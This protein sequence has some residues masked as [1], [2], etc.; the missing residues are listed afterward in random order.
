VRHGNARRLNCT[1]VR[2]RKKISG[3]GHLSD[4]RAAPAGQTESDSDTERGDFM[5][6]NR[7]VVFQHVDEASQRCSHVIACPRTRVAA[8]VDP[9]ASLSD[10][11]QGTIEQWKLRPRWVLQTRLGDLADEGARY[12]SLLSSLGLGERALPQAAPVPTPWEDLPRIALRPPSEVPRSDVEMIEAGTLMLGLRRSMRLDQ[13][14]PRY[15]IGG[16]ALASYAGRICGSARLAFG[17]IHIRILTSASQPGVLSYLAEDR[18]FTGRPLFAPG[19]HGLATPS[20][21]LWGLPPDTIVYPGSLRSGRCISSIGQ[22]RRLTTAFEAGEDE[23]GTYTEHQS[24]GM[25]TDSETEP[26][27]RR[28]PWRASMH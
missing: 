11:L 27:Q 16:V 25:D 5:L 20:E 19:L 14:S 24:E 22:E 10:A 23:P 12:V 8:F 3:I 18:L 2:I 26:A 9:V 28:S 13:V 15:T 4:V 1:E 7:A 17:A 6:N 21:Q